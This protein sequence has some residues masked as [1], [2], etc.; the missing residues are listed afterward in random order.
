MSTRSQVGLITERINVSEPTQNNN[1]SLY[2]H[3]RRNAQTSAKNH[4][5]S[6]IFDCVHIY[7]DGFDNILHIVE[8][9]KI[10]T[11]LI[12]HILYSH[13]ECPRR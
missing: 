6:Y 13:Y 10:Q 1:E 9:M 11:D 5:Y 12:A 2:G 8:T 3:L 7:D 4:R